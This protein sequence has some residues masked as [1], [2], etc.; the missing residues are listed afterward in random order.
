MLFSLPG[1]AEGVKL[2]INYIM[3]RGITNVLIGFIAGAAAGAIAG[4]LMAP[5]RGIRTRKHLAWSVRSSR[6]DLAE[7]MKEKVDD[8]KHEVNNMVDEMQKKLHEAE[9][10]MRERTKKGEKR[11]VKDIPVN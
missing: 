5:D 11:S 9:R 7:T 10:Q 8:L 3:E 2:K 4:I 1:V 6:R